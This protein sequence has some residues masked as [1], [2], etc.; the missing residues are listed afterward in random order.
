MTKLGIVKKPLIKISIHIPHTGDDGFE[1]FQGESL[2]ISIHIPR[3]GDDR[4]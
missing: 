2:F 1:I 3:V 4:P